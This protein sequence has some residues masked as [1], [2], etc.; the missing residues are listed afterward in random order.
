MTVKRGYHRLRTLD[1]RV[2]EGPLVLELAEDGTLLSYH[3]LRQEEPE[4]EWIGG[5]YTLSIEH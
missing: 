5:D 4:T 2:V 3:P 1:G